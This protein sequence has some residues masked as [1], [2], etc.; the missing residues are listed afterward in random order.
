MLLAF[1]IYPLLELLVIVGGTLE[2]L[3][4]KVN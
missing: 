4:L 3:E 2:L 1:A